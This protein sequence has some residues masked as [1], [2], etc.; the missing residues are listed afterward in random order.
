[1]IKIK[2]KKGIEAIFFESTK[3]ITSERM[4]ELQKYALVDVGVGSSFQAIHNHFAMLDKFHKAND[5]SGAMKETHNLYM[6]LNFMI[7]KID[8]KSLSFAC[9]CH[10]INGQIVTDFSQENLS[11]IS[12]DISR[13]G[14]T[15]DQVHTTLEYLKKKLKTS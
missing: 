3:E 7:E 15:N 13:Y 8:I 14:F 6:N 4:N 1:M 5:I 11:R 12:E 2:S 9:M 10:T